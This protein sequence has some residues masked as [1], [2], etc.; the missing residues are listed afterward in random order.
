M[1]KSQ[2][3]S[4]FSGKLWG[5]LQKKKTFLLS[6]LTPWLILVLLNLSLASL[7]YLAYGSF[8]INDLKSKPFSSAYLALT[9][10]ESEQWYPKVPVT[11][12]A[13]EKAYHVSPA[14]RE[15]REIIEHE[16]NGFFKYC[17]YPN[18]ILGA[19]FVWTL[20]YA[21]EVAG[22]H[23]SLPKSEEFYQRIA[24]EINRAFENGSLKKR[25]HVLPIGLALDQRHLL[26]AFYK[27]IESGNFVVTFSMYS[28]YPTPSMGDESEIRKFQNITGQ[29]A[30]PVAGTEPLYPLPAKAK[31]TLLEWIAKIY[32]YVNPILYFFSFVAFFIISGFMLLRKYRL[33]I[34]ETWVVAFLFFLIAFSRI[35]LM[36]LIWVS[37][38][39][40]VNS[41]YLAVSYPFLLLFEM[42]SLIMFWRIIGLKKPYKLW[43]K[44]PKGL[45]SP[46]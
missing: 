42:M 7:N 28:P 13:R 14:F 46:F 25:N 36:S 30:T 17:P 8:V 38:W 29:I 4:N 3:A 15:L 21:A 44:Q 11:F 10:I 45:I 6:I 12:E 16:N 32:Q 27:I 24:D 5:V 41:H 23:Q 31:F 19:H 26:P 34:E 20:R 9:K 35:L 43:K 40:G 39:D 37:Q 1:I 33:L 22:Y 18:E 2:A